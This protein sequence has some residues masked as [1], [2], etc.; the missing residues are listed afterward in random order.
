MNWRLMLYAMVLMGVWSTVMK[1]LRAL[2]QRL[3]AVVEVVC[4]WVGRGG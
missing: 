2:V 3:R 4:G 1:A